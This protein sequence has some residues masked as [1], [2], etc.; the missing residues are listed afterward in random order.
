MSMD[1]LIE[2]LRCH[3]ESSR[4]GM[5]ACHLGVVRGTSLKGFQ[6]QEIEVIYDQDAIAKI[7]SETRN[8]D[9]IVDVLVE[10]S[11]GLLKVGDEILAVA[12]AGE[13]RET[14]FPA[15][16]R[17]VDRIKAEAVQKREIPL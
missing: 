1:N 15:L 10:T 14:V 16:I 8:M 12:V 11:E 13:T 2:R 3:P 5:I 6:V 9:G 17:T 7:I 4:I